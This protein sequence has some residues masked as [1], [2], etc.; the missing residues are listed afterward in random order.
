MKDI[1]KEI[2]AAI[3]RFILA[4][5]DLLF[6]PKTFLTKQVPN[7]EKK[8]TD[9]LI[10][11]GVSLV[12]TLIIK[13]PLLPVQTNEVKYLSSDA[14]WKFTILF[15]ETVVIRISW[16]LMGSK[17]DF[18]DFFILNAYCFGVFSVVSHLVLLLTATLRQ[19]TSSL[20]NI[21]FIL[22]SLAIG[23]WAVICWNAYRIINNATFY[24][25]ILALIAT[26]LISLP[27]LWLLLILRDAFKL[28]RLPL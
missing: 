26:A 23:I 12:I 7:D 5:I 25:S 20:S 6:Q 3:P 11:L 13:I 9:A 16:N 28:G 10:F 2:L 19:S 14:I 18:K 21:V 24:R 4:F 17:T 22:S 27:A 15:I 1:V 8:L